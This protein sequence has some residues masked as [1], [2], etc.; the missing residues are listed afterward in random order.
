[1][2]NANRLSRSMITVLA[3]IT[4]FLTFICL[5]VCFVMFDSNMREGDKA[6]NCGKADKEEI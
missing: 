1:M 2:Y 6:I 5:N 4:P 3:I